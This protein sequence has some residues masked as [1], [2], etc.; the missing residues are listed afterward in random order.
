LSITSGYFNKYFNKNLEVTKGD[1]LEINKVKDIKE[2][3]EF[4][5]TPKSFCKYC[6]RKGVVFGIKYGSTKKEIGEWT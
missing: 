4:L 6:N 1:V 2:V 5:H 3:Y